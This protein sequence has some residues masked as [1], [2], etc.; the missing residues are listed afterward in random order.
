MELVAGLYEG[1]ERYHVDLQLMKADDDA[2]VD[3]AARRDVD[4]V[5]WLGYAPAEGYRPWIA[6]F[7][8]RQIPV[9]LCDHYVDD[10]PCDAVLS[11]NVGG[12]YQAAQYVAGLGHRRVG[13]LNQ[14]L[15]LCRSGG[16]DPGILR[17][18]GAER[19]C[20]Q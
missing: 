13:I 1:G 4:G 2:G 7:E 17:R 10:L 6:E 5:I 14:D 16:K 15:P 19:G 12:A 8:A 11:D 20:S 18:P 9:V 3:L